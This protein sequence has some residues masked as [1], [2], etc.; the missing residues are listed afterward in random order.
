MAEE[1]FDIAEKLD[2]HGGNIDWHGGKIVDANLKCLGKTFNYFFQ[3]LT[4]LEMCNFLSNNYL[5][6]RRG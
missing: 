4:K 6:E 2:C 1:N 5:I 3:N